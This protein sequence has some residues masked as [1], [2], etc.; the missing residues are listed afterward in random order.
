M[1]CINPINFLHSLFSWHILKVLVWIR[2]L[3][4]SVNLMVVSIIGWCGMLISSRASLLVCSYLCYKIVLC[5]FLPL[6]LCPWF[7]GSFHYW[8]MDWSAIF[9]LAHFT[10]I[11]M[12]SSR[13][14]KYLYPLPVSNFSYLIIFYFSFLF[15]Y[16]DKCMTVDT[17][18]YLGFSL[19]QLFHLLVFLLLSSVC[20][21]VHWKMTK[22]K[23]G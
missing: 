23:K 8:L 18:I 21:Q 1:K 22:K 15:I 2:G 4:Q 12:F 10:L 5:L 6:V 13:F 17:L 11:I 14:W 20:F 19:T 3:W 9:V 7:W 16:K